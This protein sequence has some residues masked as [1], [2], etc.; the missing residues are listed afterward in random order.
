MKIQSRALDMCCARGN[1]PIIPFLPDYGI[2]YA[3]CGLYSQGDFKASLCLLK[4]VA[5]MGEVRNK[6]RILVGKHER[7]T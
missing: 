5:R 3:M 4:Y 6:H 2:L 1:K 7:L